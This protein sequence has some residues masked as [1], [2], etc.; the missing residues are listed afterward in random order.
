LAGLVITAAP[1]GLASHVTT[2]AMTGAAVSGGA[3]AA[4]FMNLSKTKIAVA[5]LAL[6]G[7]TTALVLEHQANTRLA[8]ENAHLHQANAQL[9]ALREENARLAKL[10]ADA[11]ELARLRE[12]QSELLRLRGELTQLR[13]KVAQAANATAKP[14]ASP[15]TAPE[16]ESPVVTFSTTLSARVPPGQTLLAGGWKTLEGKRTLILLTPTLVNENP[17]DQRVLVQNVIVQVP[18]E[19]LAQL[20]WDQ[21][22][23]ETYDSKQQSLIPEA[24]FRALLDQLKQTKGVDVLSSP[25]INTADGV[26]ASVSVGQQ[27]TIAGEKVMLGPTIEVTP[28]VASDGSGIGL[29]I[30]A[31]INQLRSPPVQE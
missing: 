2:V 4:L 9:D 31:H 5:A 27:R 18:E 28:T 21:F 20:G 10:E 8:E 3:L 15:S 19:V 17:A 22:K 12:G 7:L 24:Q 1:A 6:A 23:T 25:R 14:S 13:K 11:T 29:S 26:G 16:P 30:S